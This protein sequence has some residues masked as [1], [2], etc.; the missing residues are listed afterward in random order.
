V[1]IIVDIGQ[2]ENNRAVGTV[3]A[4]GQSISRS[5]SG[6]LELLALIENLY[7]VGPDP[8]EDSASK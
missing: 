2:D 5:F 1:E 8:D 4:V 6:N 3:R 7:R